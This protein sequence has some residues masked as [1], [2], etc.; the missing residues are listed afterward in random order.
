MMNDGS[1]CVVF[2]IGNPDRGDDAAGRVV[3]RRLRSFSPANI[4][5][6]EH[7]G[8]GTAL[9]ARLD[10][11]AVSFL[12]D[13]STSRAPPGTVRRFDVSAGPLPDLALGLS[14]HGF[15]LAMAIALARALGQLPPRGIIYTIEGGSF[16][17]GAPLSPPVQ[18]AV[19]EVARRL[20]A[21]ITDP[22]E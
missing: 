3:A 1:R 6:M 2:G 4:E 8:E 9:L 16:E 7:D 17:P 5:I 13:A 14:T 21:E 18:A 22:A 19:A 10:G 20:L 12:V 15:G 11:A